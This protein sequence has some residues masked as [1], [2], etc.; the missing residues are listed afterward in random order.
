AATAG[1]LDIAHHQGDAEIAALAEFMVPLVKG[2]CSERAV[3]VASLGVQIHGGM[4]FIEETG[5]AQH[6]RDA[7]IL[8]IYEGTTAI[9]A[10]DLLGRKVMRDG[11]TTAR[12]FAAGIAETETELAQGN[13]TLQAIGE[14]LGLARTAFESSLD[15]LQT[16]S[17][18]DIDAAF[19]GS[20]PFLMLSGTLAAGWKLADGARAAQAAIDAGQ[21]TDFMTQK[22]ATA[23]FFAQHVLPE[24]TVE[25]TRIL[26]G[27]RSLL[28]AAFPE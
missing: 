6:Y 19:A 4:G 18:K 5:A 27:S 26:H 13:T 9:Q 12:L 11:G 17:R 10:N 7:R 14:N 3:E 2:Y 22:V 8:P 23:L 16:N 25:Q 20:V 1:L 21:D 24:C 15:W 28:D